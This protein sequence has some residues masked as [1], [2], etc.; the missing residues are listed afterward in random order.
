MQGEEH[1]VNLM[2]ELGGF[3]NL[4]SGLLFMALNPITEFLYLILMI[5]RLYLAH[6]VKEN[7]FLPEK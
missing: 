4:L 5:K 1:V 2:S 6:T 7:L 3:I